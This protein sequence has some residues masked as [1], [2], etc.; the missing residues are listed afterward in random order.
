[1]SFWFC[2]EDTTSFIALR[3]QETFRS[4]DDDNDGEINEWEFTQAWLWLGFRGEEVEIHEIFRTVDAD[5]RGLINEQEFLQIVTSERRPELQIKA[6]LGVMDERLALVEKRFNAMSSTSI[7]RRLLQREMDADV[8]K[9]V[10]GIIDKLSAMTSAVPEMG[11]KQQLYMNILS[12][13]QSCDTNGNGQLNIDQYK[14]A[15]KRN[16]Y[17]FK[18]SFLQNFIQ[19][20]WK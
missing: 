6:N 4:F 7:R 20:F 1:M 2:F 16:F 14:Q 13:F 17:H 8:E 10:E 19:S 18:R 5:N 15:W 12:T 3:L 9:K 11:R